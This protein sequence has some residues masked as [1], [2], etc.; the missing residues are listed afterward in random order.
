M[1]GDVEVLYAIK[2]LNTDQKLGPKVLLGYNANEDIVAL[3]KVISG[4]TYNRLIDDPDV[5]DK[6]V[7]KWT[8]FSTWDTA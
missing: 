7:V 3:R 4:I 5:A 8:E 6:S 2:D 1:T